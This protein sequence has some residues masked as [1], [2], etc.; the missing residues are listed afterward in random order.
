MATK[1]T[2]TIKRSA[3]GQ[4]SSPWI[5]VLATM[6]AVI[7][8]GNMWKFPY[9]VGENGGGSFV[10]IYL[11]CI[12]V[13]DVPLLMVELMIGRLARR[14]PFGAMKQLSL[15]SK[16][17][18]V[19][20]WVGAL[21][22][23]T[24]AVLLSYYSIIAGW[25]LYYVFEAG[26]GNFVQATPEEVGN[27]FSLFLSNPIAL[28]FGQLTIMILTVGIVMLGIQKGLEYAIRFLFPS[29]L[30]ILVL[31]IIYAL[32]TSLD[33]FKQATIFLFVSVV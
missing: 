4:W 7:G 1:D 8:L 26:M 29:M 9:L 23:L 33:T 10:I 19:W 32:V 27:T 22:I 2:V 17:N 24:G 25:G 21:S 3:Q 18:P 14:N 16:R 31:L 6:C 12:I 15:A 20:R 28:L 11:I 5:F 30:L 13:V